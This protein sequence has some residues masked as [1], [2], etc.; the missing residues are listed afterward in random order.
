MSSTFMQFLET[1][2]NVKH[3]MT[4]NMESI[5]L[6]C[7]QARVIKYLNDNEEC[8]ASDIVRDLH[9]DKATLSKILV[10]LERKEIVYRTKIRG[11]RKSVFIFLTQKGV[12]AIEDINAAEDGCCK[13]MLSTIPQEK[14]QTFVEVLG[15]IHQKSTDKLQILGEERK[16]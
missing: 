8:K 14:M 5:D 9:I 2:K 1:A 4:L 13:D 11:N 10:L 12:N 15:E 16:E 7:V 6:T 3:L